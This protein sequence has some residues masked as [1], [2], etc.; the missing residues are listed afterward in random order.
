MPT[1]LSNL[2]DLAD[3]KIDLNDF[4]GALPSAILTWPIFAANDTN[5]TILFGNV[6]SCPVPD[7]VRGHSDEDPNH[8][9]SCGGSEFVTPA[10][11]AAAAGALFVVAVSFTKQC[12][13]VLS[14]IGTYTRGRHEILS[15][16][17]NIVNVGHACY[18]F[19]YAVLLAS[20]G[21]SIT[22]WNAD[23]NFEA[24][25]TFL[26]LSVS[27]KKA[28]NLIVLPILA[29]TTLLLLYFVN[30]GW[31]LR[32]EG[33][34]NINVHTEE[35]ATE[36]KKMRSWRGSLKLFGI[37]AYTIILMVAFDFVYVFK[38]ATNPTISQSSKVLANTALSQ[39]KSTLLN[40]RKNRTRP[41]CP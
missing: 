13:S 12:E 17:S 16:A 11:L 33:H 22:Y 35:T 40:E 14:L 21:L 29:I 15:D 36:K 37:F 19:V 34:N 41:T 31:N 25:P 38:V 8:A 5:T 23:S 32:F 18:K 4:S 27:L 10:I 9:Y 26:K 39:F 7:S 3:L 30:W 20:I 6:W 2:T 24:Q 28:S 1:S